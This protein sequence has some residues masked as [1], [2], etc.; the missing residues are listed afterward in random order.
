MKPLFLFILILCCCFSAS[1]QEEKSRRTAFEISLS[2]NRSNV[3]DE[4]TKDRFGGGVEL[5]CSF[6]DRRRINLVAGLGYD[7]T[8]QFKKSVFFGGHGPYSS[9]KD[10]TA[11]IHNLSIPISVRA[12]FGKK[13][14]FFPEIG[15][16]PTIIVGS[17]QKGTGGDSESTG[18]LIDLPRSQHFGATFGLGLKIPM[19]KIAL[20]VKAD[21]KWIFAYS[22]D[23]IDNRYYRLSIG[24]SFGK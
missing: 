7:L 19:N 1:S 13:I 2:A 20:I 3:A 8:G 10:V 6:F 4:N 24:I 9:Y 11:Y 5:L 23:E 12:N 15:L 18:R 17:S 16:F 14:K 22:A 21:Y